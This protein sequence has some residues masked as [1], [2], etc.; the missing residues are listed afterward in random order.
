MSLAP[1][2]RGIC[3]TGDILLVLNHFSF[4]SLSRSHNWKWEKGF[5]IANFQRIAFCIR[6]FYRWVLYYDTRGKLHE[7]FKKANSSILNCLSLTSSIL[8]SLSLAPNWFQNCS[9]PS[10]MLILN[11]LSYSVPLGN[12]RSTQLKEAQILVFRHSSPESGI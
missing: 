4:Q 2:E 1:N 11:G 5:L 6:M 3:C 7:E 12:H 8:H 9:T 10:I